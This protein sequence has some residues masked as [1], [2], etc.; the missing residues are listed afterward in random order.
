[1]SEKEEFGHGRLEP[2]DI[3]T[4]VRRDFLEY[5]MSV[6]VSRALP[7]LRDGLKPVHRRIIY[8]MDNLKI[9]ANQPHK[10]SARIVGEVIGK[11]HPHGDTA[12]YDSMV[13]M[14]QDFSYRYPL[15][16]GH[17]NFGSIDGDGAAAMRY[18]EARLT[19]MSGYLIKDIEMETV[20]FID[21]YD[22]SEIEPGYLTGYF[23]NLLANGAMGIAV[24]M[25]T[26]IPPHNLIE[27]N[28]AIIA[29]IN[30]PQITIDQLLDD[31]IQG[32]D[33]PTGALMTNGKSMREGYK[34]GKGSVRMRA[35]TKT[36]NYKGRDRIIVTE[37]P[38]QTNKVKIIEKIAD[39][40]RNK[41]INGI[42]DIRDES[43]LKEGIKIVIDLKK[44]ANPELILSQLFR[45]TPLQSSFSI[46]LLALRNNVPELLDL[47]SIIRYYV[48]YQLEIIVK[49]SVFEQKKKQARFHILEGLSKALAYIDP[50]I[51]T[52]RDS[53][54]V[55][56]ARNALMST[57]EFDED[58]VKAILEMNLQRLVGLEQ[59][60]IHNEMSEISTRLDYLNLLINDSAEQNQVLINQ[61]NEIS[62]KFGDAR[63]TETISDGLLNIDDE[64][65]IPDQKMIILLSQE[66]NLRRVDPNEF[67]VQKRGGRGIN[68]NSNNNDPIVIAAMGKTRDWVMMFTDSGKVF[69]VKAYQV[70]QYSRNSKGIPALNFLP[71]LTKEDKITAILPFRN[72]KQKFKYLVFITEKGTIKKTEIENFDRVNQNGKIAISLK[73]GDRLITVLPTTGE[74]TIFIATTLGKVIRI[75]E[76]IVRPLSRTA[77]GV[78]GIKLEEHDA[79][80]GATTSFGTDEIITISSKGNFKKTK[81]DAYRVSGRNGKGVKVMN[82]NEGKFSGLLAAR[83]TDLLLIISS[84]GNLIK[85]KVSA[86]PTLSRT[87]GGVKGINLGLDQEISAVAL[88]Y[89]KHGLEDFDYDEENFE[90]TIIFDND[91]QT[92]DVTQILDNDEDLTITE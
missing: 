64:D 66:G 10:K 50:I 54:S 6:I 59:E 76:R 31:Y 49:R 89:N 68:V 79:V 25:A 17:G 4:E 47:K 3:A 84:D 33:F 45:Q 22:A 67:K 58:Q 39:L 37:I 51:K 62:E 71:G 11:Y 91:D 48:D 7:D 65:L 14:A 29:Y 19:K 24:G 77:S 23:P 57:Y 27:V 72:N 32:P 63:R 15:V 35:K 1:M 92:I 30:N 55:E 83:E 5:S 9:T 87:A 56:I 34:T 82:L 53:Q 86:I 8:A 28:N 13:R 21:N 52:I 75:D 78:K 2:I 36:E 70:Q 85:T 46:N 44:E 18:T 90:P 20:P 60:K 12:V 16:D 80:V 26:N 42:S 61:L 74:E 81:L 38:Y 43:N 69:R 88:E 73:D 41:E 40:V